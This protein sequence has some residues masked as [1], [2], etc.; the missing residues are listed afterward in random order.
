[1]NDLQAQEIDLNSMEEFY[2]NH[3]WMVPFTLT[4]EGSKYR[5]VFQAIRLQHMFQAPWIHNDNSYNAINKTLHV[6]NIVESQTLEAAFLL[7]YESMMLIA[8]GS[9]NG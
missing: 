4:A 6:D 1:M 5:E 7:N 8:D 3:Q 9:E 2:R